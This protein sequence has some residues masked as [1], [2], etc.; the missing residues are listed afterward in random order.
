MN[1][2]L[3]RELAEQA[4]A[5]EFRLPHGWEYALVGEDSIKRFAELI[6]EECL[7]MCEVAQWGYHTHGLEKEA[8]GAISVQD[9]IK[10]HFGVE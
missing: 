9:Y 8:T 6:I 3:I 10:D 7:R 4:G 5:D 2:Q 1:E